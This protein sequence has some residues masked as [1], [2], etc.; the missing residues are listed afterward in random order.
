MRILV[1]DT[2][3]GGK[4]IAKHLSSHG[5][6]ID[7]VDVY[8]EKEGIPPALAREQIY[9]L[10]IAPVH[11]DPDYSLFRSLKIPC[12]SHH[13]AARWLLSDVRAG[14]VIEITGKQG[15]STTAAAL[16]SLMPG[17][18]ILQTSAGLV[19][20]PDKEILGRY[21]I[22][23]ASVLTASEHIP[24]NGWMIAEI[25]LGFCGIGNVGILTSGLD[26]P[27][28]QGKKS[29]LAIKMEPAHLLPVVLTAPGISLVHDGCIPVTDLITVTG[30]TAQYRYSGCSGSFTNPLLLLPG[31]KV[32]LMLA[33]GAALILGIDPA[34][35]SDFQA[36]PGRMEVSSESGYTIIDNA[37][38]GTCYSTTMD[39]FRFGKE[40]TGSRQV[41]LVIGQ[42]SASVC[43][44]FSTE[45]IISSIKEICP[46][47]VM[48]IPGDE[49]IRVP[50]VTRLCSDLDI[51]FT[52]V[53]SAGEGIT[54]AKTQ[55]NSLI[56]VSVKRWK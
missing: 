49:R 45:E 46:D 21:S 22:T 7:M 52:L 54:I 4:V 37:N 40:I 13:A 20:Y 25:S 12:I 36:L 42:E 32:P 27:V 8:R 33:A 18:G 34:P 38:S 23:P 30:T 9:D 28:A 31:Y 17:P 15:K 47:S 2:I 14:P 16:A 50:E 55:N 43:E 11:L 24:D 6:H 3:H 19:T 29:A 44:N 5:H 10:M 53:A 41:T 39:A 56:L 51:P 26:Y 48:L 1:L 35:L